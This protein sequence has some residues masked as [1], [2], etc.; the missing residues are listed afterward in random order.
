MR[1]SKEAT[2]P[3]RRDRRAPASPER[4]ELTLRSLRPK[5]VD[6]LIVRRLIDTHAG[7]KVIELHLRSSTHLPALHPQPNQQ[8]LEDTG[9]EAPDLAAALSRRGIIYSAIKKSSA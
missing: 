9:G 3:R 4:I 5:A 6:D 2:R 7:I 8:A 1:L